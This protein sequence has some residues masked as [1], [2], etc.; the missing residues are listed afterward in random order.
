MYFIKSQVWDGL[1]VIQLVDDAG[2]IATI[3]PSQG[4]MLHAFA[5]IAEDRE[6]NCVVSYQSA[7]DIHNRY[8][9]LGFMGANMS[10]YVCR[11]R[12]GSYHFAGTTYKIETGK[13]L[14]D[15]AIHGLIY[16]RPYKVMS[17]LADAKQ[18][19]LVLEYR[20][21]GEDA[22][23][24]FQFTSEVTYKLSA[25]NSL[26]VTTKILNTDAGNIPI[27]HGWHPYFGFGETVDDLLLEFQSSHHIVFDNTLLPT[28]EKE[29]YETFTSLKKIGD[30]QFDD[31]F[32]LDFAHCHPMAVLRSNTHAAQVEIYPDKTYPYLQLYIPPHRQSVAMENLSALPDAF[33]NQTGLAVLSSGEAATF[34]T[35]YVL[36]KL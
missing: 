29:N 22:G 17:Q 4:A 25:G 34:T 8:E 35:K 27:A 6:I 12:D 33:N 23:Y 26:Q 21:T 3:L 16:R 11:L 18:A 19:E 30:A 10:P 36:K 31:C 28:G 1:E 14:G 2:C 15:H 13:Y 32:E 7:A 24:P 5:M 9:E 20:Y